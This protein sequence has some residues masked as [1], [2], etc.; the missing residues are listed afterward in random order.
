MV[1]FICLM[2]RIEADSVELYDADGDAIEAAD[3]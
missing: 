2:A 1:V 3:Y